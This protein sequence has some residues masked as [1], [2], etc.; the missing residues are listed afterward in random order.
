MEQHELRTTMAVATRGSIQS[1]LRSQ[2]NWVMQTFP[3]VIV[4][5]AI[6]HLVELSQSC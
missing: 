3:R 1:M 5:F 2:A 4:T 6:G